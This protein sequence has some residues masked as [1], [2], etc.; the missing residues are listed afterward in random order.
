MMSFPFTQIFLAC[1]CTDLEVVN[2]SDPSM[3]KSYRTGVSMSK[4]NAHED[5]TMT[6]VAVIGRMPFGQVITADQYL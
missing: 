6:E 5:G 3:I 2:V 4:I 1:R